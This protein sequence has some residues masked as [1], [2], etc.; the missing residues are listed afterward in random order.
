MSR[1]RDL[2]SILTASSSMATDTEVSAVSAQIPTF[3]AGK[4]FLINGAFDIWQRGT[5]IAGGNGIYTADRWSTFTDNEVRTVTRQTTGDTTNL[6]HI[7]YCARFQRA[8]TNTGTGRLLFGQSL[9]TINSIP[10]AG[11]TVTI[12]LYARA[13]A[14]YSSTSN[15]LGVRLYGGTGTDQHNFVGYTSQ[16]TIINSNAT[17]TTSWQRFSFTGTVGESVTEVATQIGYTP[18]GTAGAADY[19]EI[20]GVQLE[21]GSVAT[22][23]SRAGGDI[24]GELAKCQRYYEQSA[25]AG[26]ALSEGMS[27]TV[28]GIAS[29]YSASDM[30]SQRFDFKVTKRAVPTMTYYRSNDSAT[31][32]RW[33]Y[34]V[35]GWTTPSSTSNGL[36]GYDSFNVYMTSSSAFT[37]RDCYIIEGGG[38][39]ASAEL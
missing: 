20:T 38:W 24:Q 5:T 3:V 33:V 26:T 31:N 35:S 39:S 1:I 19:F 22:S 21:I 36:V 11:K 15:V 29:A 6:P 8:N 12:S 2:A 4:N 25:A 28:N 23:F 13:G 18:T 10:L 27:A 7:Q 34:Y 9:E 32:G 37:T 14:N 30:R 16:S 17:L